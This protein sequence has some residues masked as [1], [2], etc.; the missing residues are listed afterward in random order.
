MPDT[1]LAA[2]RSAIRLLASQTA[3]QRFALL[4]TKWEVLAHSE[5]AFASPRNLDAPEAAL[6]QGLCTNHQELL[7]AAI[8]FA[9]SVFCHCAIWFSVR[10]CRAI[11][12]EPP[13]SP[14]KIHCS[15]F[16][17]STNTSGIQ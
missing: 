6:A 11:D 17:A 3:L 16:L 15:T 7:T 4:F 9:R 14:P 13:L 2:V 1:R 5:H 10:V 12:S 8:E